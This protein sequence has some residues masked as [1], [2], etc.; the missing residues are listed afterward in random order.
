MDRQRPGNDCSFYAVTYGGGMFVA[1]GNAGTFLTSPDGVNWTRRE[2]GTGQPLFGVT[3]GN[4]TF[5]AVGY[6]GTIIQSHPQNT[7]T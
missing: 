7:L 6:N 3:Y 4:G 2:S 1:V 5:V